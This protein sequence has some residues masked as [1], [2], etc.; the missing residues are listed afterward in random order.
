MANTNKSK[1]DSIPVLIPPCHKCKRKNLNKNEPVCENCP[2]RNDL[3]LADSGDKEALKRYLIFEYRLG[4]D[5]SVD[6]A[7]DTTH[8]RA[9]V[10]AVGKQRKDAPAEYYERYFNTIGKRINREYKTEFT[11][12]KEVV[13]FLYEKHK[14]QKHLASIFN[15]SASFVRYMVISFGITKLTKKEVWKNVVEKRKQTNIC[16]NNMEETKYE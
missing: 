16:K 15:M 3:I 8:V 9:K 2:A 5:V 13:V 12:M 10:D 6:K 14:S 1:V 7:L 4:E 11:T